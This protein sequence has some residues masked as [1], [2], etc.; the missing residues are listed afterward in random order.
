MA[1]FLLRGIYRPRAVH[2]LLWQ[3]FGTSFSVEKD[4]V[5][6]QSAEIR[7]LNL[8]DFSFSLA[9]LVSSFKVKRYII[10]IL[11]FIK[12]NE[13]VVNI[14]TFWELWWVLKCE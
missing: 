10:V 9:L 14:F 7:Y 12:L 8:H 3:L 13:K 11:V 2:L 4:I 5:Y 1:V 6:H